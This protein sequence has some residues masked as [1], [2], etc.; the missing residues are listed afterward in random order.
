MPRPE[1]PVE[2][3][4]PF[5][6]IA[7]GLRELRRSRGLTYREMAYLTKYGV[8][9]LAAA[10][11][12]RRL[13]TWDVTRAYVRACGGDE[14]AWWWRWLQ[15]Y[16]MGV[17]RTISADEDAAPPAHVE[18]DIAATRRS[19]V[20]G[21]QRTGTDG[22]SELSARYVSDLDLAAVANHEDLVACL[23]RLYIRADSPSYRDL[24][25]QTVRRSGSQLA[26]TGLMRVRLGR[27]AIGE[28]LR[29]STF[30][31][32]AFML[33]FVEACGVDLEVDHRWGQTWDRLATQYLNR[34]AE[35]EVKQLRRQL[36]EAR[37]QAGR[38]WEESDQLRQ[39]LAVAKDLSLQQTS[40]AKEMAARLEGAQAQ[41]REAHDRLT[42]ATAA[43]AA[44]LEQTRN[45]AQ[46]RVDEARA[47]ANQVI[48][49]ALAAGVPDKEAVARVRGYF[50]RNTA[51]RLAMAYYYQEFIRGLPA[52][53][54]VPMMDVVIALD[55]SGEGAVSDYKKLLQGFIWKE[56][57]H[58]RHLAD[59]LLGNSL[60]TPADLDEA[61]QVAAANERNGVC[62][63]A[64]RRV[65][66]RPK[67]KD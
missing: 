34:G 44:E 2:P 24:E 6:D 54:T 58:A 42:E 47:W 56:R 21:Q 51:A 28:M 61:R 36:A 41:A 30:P 53:Q 65:Q 7:V 39:Q 23:E 19:V 32:K 33:T 66:Y 14:S 62:E 46:A 17:H 4:F 59:F 11:D 38:A 55:L 60:L 13:P 43:H 9:V 52:P 5:A 16:E 1:R 57:G 63:M 45:D 40:A 3:D 67:V 48:R 29:G 26:A 50:D 25:Q 18:G 49:R 31:K 10:A 12:G 35:T 22:P 64:R 20:E 37:A 8:T 27:S 15:A